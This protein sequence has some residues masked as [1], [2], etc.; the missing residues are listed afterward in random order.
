MASVSHL[1]SVPMHID[2]AATALSLN[3]LCATGM[4]SKSAHLCQSEPVFRLI[5]IREAAAGTSM[6]AA[7]VHMSSDVEGPHTATGIRYRPATTAQVRSRSTAGGRALAQTRQ[8]APS[9][10]V[11]CA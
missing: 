1:Q 11:R 2:E 9:G 8:D 6:V 10:S 4:R 7:R 5:R 3:R